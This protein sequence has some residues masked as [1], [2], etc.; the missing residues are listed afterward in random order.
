MRREP[1]HRKAHD[2]QNFAKDFAVEREYSGLFLE[3][4]LGKTSISLDVVNTVRQKA[5]VI[6]PLRIASITWP[7]EMVDWFDYHNI[8]YTVL[9]GKDREANFLNDK[10]GVYLINPESLLWLFDMVKKHKRVPWKVL[11]IDESTKFKN[12]KSKRFKALVSF[13][14]LFKKRIILSGTPCANGLHDLWAQIY[15]LDFGKALGDTY[16]KYRNR[17]FYQSDYMGFKWDPKPGAKEEIIELLKPFCL[18]IKAE[19]VIE[20]PEIVENDI[21]V[22]LPPEFMEKYRILEKK[23]FAVLDD[24]YDDDD[25]VYKVVADSAGVAYGKCRQ[26]IQG[27][28]IESLDELQKAQKQKPKTFLL[29]KTKLSALEDL[30]EELGDTPA[31]ISYQYQ[32][33]LAY[34]REICPNLRYIGSGIDIDESREIENLWNHSKIERLA[35]HPKSGAHGLNLQFSKGNHV[36][37]YCLENSYENYDQYIRRLRRQGSGHKTVFVHRFI[38]R[39]TVDEVT[40]MNLQERGDN[41]RSFLHAL[42]KYRKSQK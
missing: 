3:P 40:I 30:L 36:I 42:I 27:F 2:Y 33:D 31:L 26:L 12:H 35:M 5:L 14:K 38:A 17:F 37:F 10:Y 21:Y 23:L 8:K 19:E 28:M 34:L 22:D 11:V 13:V 9:H 1:K 16:V 29:H 4:G 15:L 24:Y 18:F 32:Q 39:G 6:A 7:N 25:E 20:L 41:Q